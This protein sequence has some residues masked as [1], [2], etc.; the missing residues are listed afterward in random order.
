MWLHSHRYFPASPCGHV[1]QLPWTDVSRIDV[2]KSYTVAYP[3]YSQVEMTA[4][5]WP[6]C[7]HANENNRPGTRD[8]KLQDWELVLW[9]TSWKR[10]SPPA[11][12][13]LSLCESEINFYLLYTIVI[14]G[15]FLSWQHI[16]YTKWYRTSTLPSC[17]MF[18][19][20]RYFTFQSAGSNRS[21]LIPR[22]KLTGVSFKHFNDIT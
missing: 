4:W 16:H 17:P 21:D 9:K 15:V 12:I 22:P 1:T 20:Y 10:S 8:G 11:L 2:N 13:S 18:E 19:S 5:W 6:R 3:A 14:I 7:D